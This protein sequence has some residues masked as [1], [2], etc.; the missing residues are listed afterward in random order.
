MK[1]NNNPNKSD[2]II[3]HKKDKLNEIIAKKNY[4][5]IVVFSETKKKCIACHAVSIEFIKMKK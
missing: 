3:G 5:N 2:K 4:A 1:T